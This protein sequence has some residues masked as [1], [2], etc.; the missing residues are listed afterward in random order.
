MHQASQS[1]S[2]P[3][4]WYQNQQSSDLERLLKFQNRVL[5]LNVFC[6][7]LLL[8]IVVTLLLPSQNVALSVSFVATTVLI[9]LLS[10][11]ASMQ[12]ATRSALNHVAHRIKNNRINQSRL[13]RD[14]D[15][16]PL[17]EVDVTPSAR[18]FADDLSLFGNRSLFHF[19]NRCNTLD[20]HNALRDAILNAG[21]QSSHDRQSLIRELARC[22]EERSEFLAW[23]S[24]LPGFQ[25]QTGNSA[26]WTLPSVNLCRIVWLWLL[27][28]T[29]FVAVS[30]TA[31]MTISLSRDVIGI[32]GVCAFGL[33]L[34]ATAVVCG[35]IHDHF[36]GAAIS[37]RS[38]YAFE[39]AFRSIV[40][41]RQ[42]CPSLSTELGLVPDSLSSA[43]RSIRHLRRIVYYFHL[44]RIPLLWLPIQ[45]LTL[46][47]CH[48]FLLSVRW[49]KKNAEPLFRC[50]DRVGTLEALC[51]LA[52]L[53][54]D[55]PDWCFPEFLE[56]EQG[57]LE[58]EAV[59]HPLQSG[60]VRIPS[61]LVV[62]PPGSIVL[63]TGSN[64]SG[65]STFLR[66]IGMNVLLAQLGSVVC[67]SRF[68]SSHFLI[69]SSINVNDS[70]ADHESLFLAELKRL[71]EI[72]VCAQSAQSRGETVLYLL[73]EVLHGTNS[74]ER[75]IALK[76]I[77]KSLAA[78]QATGLVTTHDFELAK[79]VEGQSG[80]TNMHF[81]ELETSSE[82]L[83][84]EYI[85]RSGIS[86]SI[87]AIRLLK[88]LNFPLIE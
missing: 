20:G 21:L 81:R 59:A 58:A 68:R 56:S 34:L 69:K 71:K 32:G 28:V 79:E 40:R 60:A 3:L 12:V 88:A 10:V 37:A 86:P 85:L 55:N 67:A 87:N 36:S 25:S 76:L 82:S 42:S 51:S 74:Y 18:S 16:I 65:K 66:A 15:R 17:V 26:R 29:V 70:L 80:I 39:Q 77:L 47:D 54:F 33:H 72:V 63:I 43:A 24:E 35:W 22:A 30:M 78:F 8:L 45:L 5:N 7:G 53:A 19:I 13:E 83:A 75:R 62:G 52:G 27:S 84:F 48:L 4:R 49:H 9:V 61:N 41:L 2:D 31:M 11:C 44:Y 64:M 38:L 73:D 50:I 57:V 14:W 23:T 46:W 1:V 6:G